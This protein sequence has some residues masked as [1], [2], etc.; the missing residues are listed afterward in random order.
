MFFNIVFLEDFFAFFCGIYNKFIKFL[1][2]LTNISI[3]L[4]ILI[5]EN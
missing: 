5:P 3:T 2:D 4:K 1:K